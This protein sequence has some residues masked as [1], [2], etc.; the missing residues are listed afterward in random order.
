MPRCAEYACFVAI[1]LGC[2]GSAPDQASVE[3][4]DTALVLPP[5]IQIPESTAPD[6]GSFRYER[7]VDAMT[8]VDRSYIS[9]RPVGGDASLRGAQLVWRCA[10]PE[11]ELIIAAADFLTTRQPVQVQWRLDEDPASVPERW[12]VSTEGTAAFAPEE[13]LLT[14]TDGAVTSQR[15]RTRLAVRVRQ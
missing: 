4:S 1:A 8:D 11:I 15:L 9:A 2:V 5:E 6:L 7:V 13:T 10:G 14:L 12:S 3:A